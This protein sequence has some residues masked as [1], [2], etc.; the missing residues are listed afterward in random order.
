MKT[1]IVERCG[2]TQKATGLCGAHY[3]RQFYTGSVDSDRPVREYNSIEVCS[4]SNCINRHYA[5][6]LCHNHYLKLK[7]QPITQGAT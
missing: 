5:K 7:R 3:Q 4:N 6:G 2:R 1:C